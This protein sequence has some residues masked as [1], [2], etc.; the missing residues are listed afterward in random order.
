[1]VH[2]IPGYCFAEEVAQKNVDVS[3]CL[4]VFGKMILPI[5]RRE[6]FLLPAHVGLF[7]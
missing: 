5:F 4:S 7:N 3:K 6:L 2:N 1:M